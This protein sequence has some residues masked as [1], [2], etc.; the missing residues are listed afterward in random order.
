M[1]ALLRNWRWV[2]PLGLFVLVGLHF[3]FPPTHR[4]TANDTLSVG[5]E[6]K[7]AFY[8]L[9]DSQTGS[10]RRNL[11][12]L[13]TFC[14]GHE[15]QTLCFLGPNREPS[16]AEWELLLD[17]VADGGQLLYAVPFEVFDRPLAYG[18]EKLERIRIP[19]LRASF[20]PRSIDANDDFETPFEDDTTK[21]L[22][23]SG[24]EIETSDPRAENLLVVDGSPQATRFRYGSG[25][26]VLVA[27]D[28]PFTNFELVVGDGGVF[29]YRLLETTGIGREVHFDES[30]N[31]S[32]TPKIVGILFDP[33]LRPLTIQLLIVT[34]LF[35]WWGRER[36]GPPL[37]PRTPP[38][39]DVVGHSD[40]LGMLVHQ[41]GDGAG[42]LRAYYN[43]LIGELGLGRGTASRTDR[44]LGPVARRLGVELDRVKEV[45]REA[46]EACQVRQL[47]RRDAAKHIRRLAKLRRAATVS[48]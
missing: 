38:H 35:V 2:W 7:K 1:R 23:R 4:G 10:A 14:Q 18:E 9:V 30:L 42:A 37:L 22:W 31:A 44:A 33:A 17:W 11:E 34:W 29:G 41:S 16:E 20:V 25:R 24:A 43:Q 48:T 3:W 45:L 15:W 21:L 47:S 8:L 26:I 46:R 27:T 40:A 12:S 32:A 6:G 5:E 13:E 19:R 28:E 36:F 39:R